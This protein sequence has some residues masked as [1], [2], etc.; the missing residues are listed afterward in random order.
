[1][2]Q[3]EELTNKLTRLQEIITEAKDI[4]SSLEE[5]CKEQDEL[6]YTPVASLI[7]AKNGLQ[8]KFLNVCSSGG[9]KTI[10]QL[11]DVGYNDFKKYRNCGSK[12][13]Y[14]VR[15]ALWNKYQIDW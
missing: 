7:I 3:T 4:I 15:E 6:A 10:Q 1:M 13:A 11:I 14:L 12:T 5:F 8:T 2:K 9:I